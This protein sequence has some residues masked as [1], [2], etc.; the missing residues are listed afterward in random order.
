MTSFNVFLVSFIVLNIFIP[1]SSASQVKDNAPVIRLRH[2]E[3]TRKNLNKESPSLLNAVGK[4]SYKRSKRNMEA[5]A[6]KISLNCT[7]NLIAPIKGLGSDI[8]LTAKHCLFKEIKR[9]TWVSQDKNNN[10]IKREG[11]VIYSDDNLD[12]AM[13]KLTKAVEYKDINPLIVNDEMFEKENFKKL[14]KENYLVAGF[15]I[16]WLGDYG[17]KLTYEDKPNFI[18]IKEN[19][20]HEGKIG[21]ITYQGDSGGA[22]IYKNEKNEGYLVGI[23]SYI[24]GDKNLFKNEKD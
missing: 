19:K 4:L 6:K 11:K 15:S 5:I 23:M 18:E 9:Y 24:R 14:E 2:R 10:K 7:A 1:K 12:W 13:I 20:L 8:I 21:A 17:K 16:D 3:D 22:I